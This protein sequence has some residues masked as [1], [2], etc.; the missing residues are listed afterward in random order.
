MNW[1]QGGDFSKNLL[2]LQLQLTTLLEGV[3]GNET[4][5]LLDTLA[6]LNDS[7]RSVIVP[8]L[9]RV[10]DQL[11]QSGTRMHSEEDLKMQDFEN[12]L[13]DSV[14]AAM[15]QESANTDTHND[16]SGNGARDIAKT[17]ATVDK[18]A[19]AKGS[20][21]LAVVRGG[22]GLEPLSFKKPVRIPALIDLNKIRESRKGKGSAS[23]PVVD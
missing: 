15:Q 1:S 23:S 7:E 14:L 17:A 13:F 20:G 8:L 21:K 10:I 19:A 12:S 16:I 2:S 3:G 11:I 6:K 9:T 22:R 18:N 4:A 5:G